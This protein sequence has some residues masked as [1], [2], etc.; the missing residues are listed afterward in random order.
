MEDS[1]LASLVYYHMG[2]L[3]EPE[4]TNVFELVKA[5]QKAENELHAQQKICDTCKHWAPYP[6]DEWGALRGAGTCNKV[7]HIQDVSDR[8]EDQ[9]ATWQEYL[10]L[11][12]EHAGLLAAVEDGS[13]YKA[14]L[15]TMPTFGCVQHENKAA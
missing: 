14:T 13:G 5:V 9:S 4:K 1:E 11:K 15:I 8:K 7:Q 12:T 3:D 10:E 6:A 2:R